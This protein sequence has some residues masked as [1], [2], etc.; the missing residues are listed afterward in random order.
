MSFSDTFGFAF[1]IF[2]KKNGNFPKNCNGL[3]FV[4]DTHPSER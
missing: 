2:L 3:V 1:S 4:V